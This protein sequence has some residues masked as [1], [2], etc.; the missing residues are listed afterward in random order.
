MKATEY[1]AA[2]KAKL[3]LTSDYKLAKALNIPSSLIA[4]Y[5]AGKNV[6]GPLV[7]F[8]VAEILGDQPAAVIAD[9]E[10]E[11]AEKAEKA[12]D[13]EEWKG[14]VKKL[15]GVAATILVAMGIGGIPNADA[16]L[17]SQSIEQQSIHRIN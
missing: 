10:L 16:R 9:F 2:V 7:A 8:K 3:N 1:L 6:P 5:Q 13:A 4:K 11:R 17:A 12:D 15:G 14:F